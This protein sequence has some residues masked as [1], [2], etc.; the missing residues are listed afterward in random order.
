M[1]LVHWIERLVPVDAL[2]PEVYREWRPLVRDAM[3]FVISRMSTERLEAKIT[4]QAQLPVGTSPEVRLTSL[5]RKMPGLQKLGQVLARNRHLDP[6]L[7]RELLTLE[8]GIRD[9]SF[10]EIR[11]VI[12]SELGPL[13][14]DHGVQ[15][16]PGIFSEA[17]VSAVVRFRY[18]DGNGVFKVLK[19]H[20][21][22]C[23]ADDMRLLQELADYLSSDAPNYGLSGVNISET[24][25]DIRQLLEH[26]VKFDYERTNLAEATGIFNEVRGV[27]VPQI[28][29]GLC[30]R[31]VTAMT[32]EA[33]IKATDLSELPPG[34]R[35]TIAR[36][37]AEALLVAPLFSPSEEALFH[38]DPHAGNL[39]YDEARD[40]LVILDW[41]LT[42]RLSR[43]QRRQFSMLLVMLMLRDVE[44]AASAIRSLGEDYGRV[45]ETTSIFLS[46]IPMYRI[47]GSL[48]A[49][50]LLD[51]LA[52]Q[53]VHFPAELLMFRKS[54]FTLDGVLHDV[55][56][57]EV[58]LDEVLAGSM[59]DRWPS[60][61]LGPSDWAAILS[62]ASL[63]G[64]RLWLQLL[65]RY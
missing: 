40:T 53:G 3:S 47:P 64:T 5:I 13:L 57:S 42:G 63:Y 49:I 15:I 46:D 35:R 22:G 12:E 38:A 59:P 28:I 29:P 21:A 52:F 56:G 20:I 16:E 65:S 19:P 43:S 11:A 18:R 54:V 51:R 60:L 25:A 61:P 1:Q 30:T 32:E 41:A 58:G 62:S 2:V 7:R 27:R 31:T 36:R 39:L 17:S 48:D 6:A 55:A 8:N 44:G 9:V 4:E 45:R 14:A 50:R 37:L 33:G 24:F 26:E 23:F 10:D 34:T